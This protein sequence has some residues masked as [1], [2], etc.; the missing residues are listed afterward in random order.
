MSRVYVDHAHRHKPGGT[1]PLVPSPPSGT[2]DHTILATVPGAYYKVPET[3]GVWHDSSGADRDATFTDLSATAGGSSPTRG[4]AAPLDEGDGSLCVTVNGPTPAAALNDTSV[5]I[6]DDVFFDFSGHSPFTVSAL[7]RPAAV[8]PDGT[9]SQGILGNSSNASS[10]GITGFGLFVKSANFDPD[11]DDVG[12]KAAF[13]RSVAPGTG[14]GHAAAYST[15]PLVAGQ[16]VRLTG[17]YDGTTVG[18]YLDEVPATGYASDY[19][20]PNPSLPTSTTFR[21]G[22][23]RVGEGTGGSYAPFQGE[24]DSIIVWDRALT[25]AEITAIVTAT[26]EGSE[27]LVL[28]IDEDGQLGWV[29]PTVEVTTGG[30]TPNETPGSDVNDFLSGPVNGNGW[31]LR[32]HY[33]TAVLYDSTPGRFDIPSR[34][35]VRVPFNTVRIYRTWEPTVGSASV[36]HAWLADD[37]GL[38]NQARDGLLHVTSEMAA[39]GSQLLDGYFTFEYPIL[40]PH[41]LPDDDPEVEGGGPRPSEPLPGDLIAAPDSYMRAARMVNATTGQIVRAGPD[42][43][44][45]SHNYR[46]FFEWEFWFPRDAIPVCVD[47]LGDNPYPNYPNWPAR[48]LNMALPYPKMSPT[49]SFSYLGGTGWYGS[50]LAVE[51]RFQAGANLCL[52]AWQDSPWPLRFSTN[53]IPNVHPDLLPAYRNLPYLLLQYEYDPDSINHDTGKLKL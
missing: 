24:I 12:G 25:A 2:V 32:A 31:H 47:Y 4:V 51:T 39:S 13:V 49:E 6:V 7:I 33:E 9:F 14:N 34:K 36:K 35:W 8:D 45:D 40:D 20:D 21:F 26:E 52:Q 53:R 30:G 48:P 15:S 23:A 16:W 1:D 43:A 11:E 28:G 10:G 29:D 46:H 18:L 44:A 27:G 17:V 42:P 41:M 22:A 3:S 19:G 38:T 5:G 50:N 37:R